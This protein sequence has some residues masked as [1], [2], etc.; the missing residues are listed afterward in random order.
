[1]HLDHIGYAVKHI[2]QAIQGFCDLGFQ[3]GEI[4]QDPERKI[5][6]AFGENNGVVIELISPLEKGS[7]VDRT[8]RKNGN[9]PYHLCYQSINLEKDIEDLTKKAFQV[10]VPPNNAIAFEGRKVA[11]LYHMQVGLIELVETSENV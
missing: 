4:I 2:E 5:S 11:F 1:M 10:I 8:L 6:I 9:T 7:P 3:F